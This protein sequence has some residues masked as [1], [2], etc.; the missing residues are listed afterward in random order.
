QAGNANRATWPNLVGFQHGIPLIADHVFS[1]DIK[2]HFDYNPNAVR[3]R[4]QTG[5]VLN[6]VCLN[7][8][9]ES[10]L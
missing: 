10:I 7:I 4:G 3:W 8:P 2:I 5:G 1:G 6:R 9:M